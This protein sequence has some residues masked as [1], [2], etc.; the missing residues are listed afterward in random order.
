VVAA[1]VAFS[2]KRW[3]IVTGGSAAAFER[4]TAGFADAT[5]NSSQAHKLAWR[6]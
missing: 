6:G 2:P 5:G 1:A 4:T 3:S